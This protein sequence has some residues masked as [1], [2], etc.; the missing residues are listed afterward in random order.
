MSIFPYVYYMILSFDITSDT[1]QIALY[2]G[3]VTSAF[4]FAEFSSGVAWG[5]IS[6]RVGRKPVLLTGLVGTALSMLVFGFAPSLPVALLGRALGGFLNGNMGVLQTTV[7]E[8]VTAKEH[9][10]RAYAIMPFVWCLGSI[11]G[12]ALGGALAQPSQNFPTFFPR[13][14]FFDRYPFLLPNLVCAVVL[15]VGVVIGILF[16]EETHEEKKHRRDVGI[17]TGKWLL[18]HLTT[19]RS[20]VFTDKPIQTDFKVLHSYMEDEDPPGY[21]TTDGTP[22]HSSSRAQS[23][24]AAKSEARLLRTSSKPRGVKKAFT[25]QVILN[26]LG[27]G[28]L[29]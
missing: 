12:P 13:G 23:P 28:I 11:L 2:V 19:R 10:P 27:F 25:K 4:A 26:I 8:I 5:R 9:Q 15:A 6:D 7:A 21:R 20:A 22:R 18:S 3:M 14:T 24:A 16:L 1:R 17:E 29:A